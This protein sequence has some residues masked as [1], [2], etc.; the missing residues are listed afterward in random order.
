MAL[1]DDGAPVP[2]TSLRALAHPLRSRL[3]ARLRVHGPA[4]ATQLASALETNTGSTSYHLRILAE[5]G[6]IHDTGTGG[7]RRRIWAAAPPVV[8][9]DLAG[10]DVDD[11]DEAA[12]ARWLQHDLVQYVA[13]RA[14]AWIDVQGE[15]PETWQ[16][17]CGLHDHAVLLTTEQLVALTAELAEVFARYRRVGAGSPGARRVAAYS[18]LLPVDPRHPDQNQ[19]R[20]TAAGDSAAR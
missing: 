8:R 6:H 20:T 13:Q 7:G 16:E 11:A 17:S 19:H 10:E 15:W 9:D 2:A 3:L 14:G 1:S 4:T 12:I 18:I 5:A